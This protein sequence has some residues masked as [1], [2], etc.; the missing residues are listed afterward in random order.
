MP[1]LVFLAT[2][3]AGCAVS[4]GLARRCLGL[5]GTMRENPGAFSA[6]KNKLL[7]DGA[8]YPKATQLWW[9]GPPNQGGERVVRQKKTQRKATVAGSAANAAGNAAGNGGG[10]GR[11][12]LLLGVLA[13]PVFFGVFK[14]ELP[15]RGDSAQQAPERVD[16]YYDGDAVTSPALEVQ[17]LEL[18]D[19]STVDGEYDAA[20]ASLVR[21]LEARGGTQIGAANGA[22][23]WVLPWVG[24][25]ERI[26]TNASSSAF[27]GGPSAREFSRRGVAVGQV[28]ARNYV[29]GPG[30]SG[31]TI[32]YLHSVNADATAPIK[33]LLT[34][35]GTVT[36]LGENVFQ[37]DFGTPMDEYEVLYDKAKGTDRLANCV[38]I[39]TPGG[40][41][42]GL[43]DCK[44]TD[45]GAERGAKASTLLVR[46]TCACC[47]LP[48]AIARPL[49]VRAVKLTRVLMLVAPQI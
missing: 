15:G 32:E 23:R 46:T 6:L 25:W 3:S 9:G 47:P 49:H 30:E 21:R 41:P 34:R 27:L 10:L 11:R 37:L 28:S 16:S 35:P 7:G 22:G 2:S 1:N 13:Q 42:S 48:G 44:P 5:D 31:I 18:L 19:E 26:W 45:G 17:L 12:A 38:P 29:Y 24:G 20:A 8:Q 40:S 4:P 39:L 33:V 14:G 43:F 36:N